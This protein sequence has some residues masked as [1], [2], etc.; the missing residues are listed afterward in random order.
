MN[1]SSCTNRCSW[2]QI[3]SCPVLS[4]EDINSGIL[5]TLLSVWVFS[6]PILKPLD[7][8]NS[9]EVEVSFFFF[10]FLF[11]FLFSFSLSHSH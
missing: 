4:A 3:I 8:L 7:A 6:D 11:V 1:I 5:Y 10:S 2:M 9:F